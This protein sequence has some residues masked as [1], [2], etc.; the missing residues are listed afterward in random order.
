MTP[1]RR[2]TLLYLSMYEAPASL[3]RAAALWREL[4]EKGRAHVQ[5][6]FS[7]EVIGSKPAAAYREALAR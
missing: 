7:R 3:C 1:L 4:G 2:P 6:H 5:Q